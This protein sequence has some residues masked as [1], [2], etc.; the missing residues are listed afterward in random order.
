M[1]PSDVTVPTV[2][3]ASSSVVNPRKGGDDD[4]S[5]VTES[6]NSPEPARPAAKKA[7]GLFP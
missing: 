5:S 3:T 2:A 4:P 1:F 7:R 6:P